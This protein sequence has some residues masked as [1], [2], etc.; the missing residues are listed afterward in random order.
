MS[1][2]LIPFGKYKGQ[3]I[4]AIQADKQYI[5]WLLAH[6]WF[7]DKYENLYTIIINNFQEPTDTPEHNAIQVKFL[8]NA[9]VLDFLGKYKSD[10]KAYFVTA[11]RFECDGWDVI[12]ELLNY[13][14]KDLEELLDQVNALERQANKEGDQNLQLQAN[15]LLDSIKNLKFYIEIKPTVSDDFPSVLRQIKSSRIRDDYGH[16]G[17]Y[18]KKRILLVGEYTGIG[19]TQDEFIAFMENEDVA[20]IFDSKLA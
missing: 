2:D 6:S 11:R 16:F 3:P 7:K 4:E 14:Q 10:L 19:A 15:E 8:N 5:N 12:I 17:R 1:N 9:Y 13:S 20:V 18:I